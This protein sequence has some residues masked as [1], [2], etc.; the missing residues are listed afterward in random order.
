MPSKIIAGIFLAQVCGGKLVDLRV[1]VAHTAK[2][3]FRMLKHPA[4]V[5]IGDSDVIGRI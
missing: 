3:F 4:K 2:N 1:C 5:F